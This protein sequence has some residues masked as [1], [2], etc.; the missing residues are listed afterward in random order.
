VQGAHSAI[1]GVQTPQPS[2]D[3]ADHPEG[4]LGFRSGDGEARQPERHKGSISTKL[5][6][7]AYGIKKGVS[8]NVRRLALMDLAKLHGMI[9]DMKQVR[10]IKSW[11]DLTDEELKALVGEG[12]EVADGEDAGTDATDGAG[13]GEVVH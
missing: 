6:E 5:A 13:D 12:G 2:A 9:V 1:G 4:H 8:D 11:G 3:Q 10:L 7:I